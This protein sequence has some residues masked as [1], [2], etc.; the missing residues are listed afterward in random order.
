MQAR[1]LPE[2]SIPLPRRREVDHVDLDASASTVWSALHDGDVFWPFSLRAVIGARALD[3]PLDVWVVRK[4]GVPWHPELGVGA[5]AEGG[6]TYLQHGMLAALGLCDEELSEA[7]ERE[8]REVHLEQA[9][10]LVRQ[11]PSAELHCLHVNRKAGCPV[12]VVRSKSH[13]KPPHDGPAS[14]R[15]MYEARRRKLCR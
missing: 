7:I 6:Y 15:C 12:L 1:T 13:D 2:T 4:V 11:V 8:R 14:P 9:L 10:A 5:V 3:A